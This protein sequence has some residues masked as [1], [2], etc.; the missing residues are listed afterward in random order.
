M[1]KS[2]TFDPVES[3]QPQKPET[4]KNNNSHGSVT[5][6]TGVSTDLHVTFDRANGNYALSDDRGNSVNGQNTDVPSISCGGVPQKI[7]LGKV[8]AGA[9]G[10]GA[11][12]G[13]LAP[14]SFLD[15]LPHGSV[16]TL[17]APLAPRALPPRPQINPQRSAQAGSLF[18]AAA[19]AAER[20]PSSSPLD[21][22]KSIKAF[23]GTLTV[24][25]PG[26]LPALCRLGQAQGII[27]P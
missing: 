26:P 2:T 10:L 19:I 1:T 24:D 7:D 13:N 15:T 8:M 14:H 6:H 12:I 23:D 17:P 16:P 20:A 4:P 18:P 3:I 21:A 9:A 27:H 5:R 11:I 25:G 22:L